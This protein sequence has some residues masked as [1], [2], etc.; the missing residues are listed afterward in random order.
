MLDNMISGLDTKPEHVFEHRI[1]EMSDMSL[2]P[3]NENY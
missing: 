1:E 3:I 2:T